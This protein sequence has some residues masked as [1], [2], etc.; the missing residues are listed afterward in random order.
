M[1]QQLEPRIRH[2]MQDIYFPARVEIVHAD[3]IVTLAEQDV[4]QVTAKET[5]TA[6]YKYAFHA[7]SS[8]PTTTGRLP[9]DEHA[10]FAADVTMLMDASVARTR[11]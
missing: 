5:S 7:N 11:I 10:G 9:D 4:T 8:H 6:S 3:D 1:P 2:Q